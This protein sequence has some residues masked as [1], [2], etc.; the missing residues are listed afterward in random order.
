MEQLNL[1]I[2]LVG[3]TLILIAFILN[4]LNKWSNDSFLYDFSN[5]LG[6][7]LMVYYAYS[8][9]SYPFLILNFVWAT[10]SFKDLVVKRKKAR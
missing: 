10:V 4:Q 7:A 9:T 6:S 1:Y 8:L 3:M 2:G 5:F